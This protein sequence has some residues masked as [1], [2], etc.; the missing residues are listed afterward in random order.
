MR[1]RSIIP[2]IATAVAVLAL[3]GCP[4]TPAM[5]IGS[6]GLGDSG[7]GTVWGGTEYHVLLFAEGMVVN[8][9]DLSDPAPVESMTGTLPGGP[10]AEYTSINYL[11]THVPE[12]AYFLLAWV[13]S[14]GT[15]GFNR[16]QDYYGFFD[17]DPGALPSFVGAQ[18]IYPNVNIP[19][20]GVVDVDLVLGVNPGA[21]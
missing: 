11:L 16:Y 5:L 18:P 21:S 12:G 15:P 4:L 17:C 8:L 19:R 6:L 9:D 3:A 7:P 2:L 1:S 10:G 13:D 14:N 20:S